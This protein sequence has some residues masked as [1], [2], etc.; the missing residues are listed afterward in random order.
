M[1]NLTLWD[2]NFVPWRSLMDMQRNMDR[3]FDQFISPSQGNAWSEAASSF[4]LPCDIDE[5]DDHYLMRFDV[6]GVSKKDINIDVR[7]NELHISGERKHER[8]S[9]GASERA[10]GKFERVL[11]LPTQI[12][13]DKI[14]ANYQDGVLSIA[15]PKQESAKARRIKIGEGKD[16]FLARLLGSKDESKKSE[17]AKEI[18]DSKAA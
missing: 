16:S 5:R 2:D 17:D 8:T 18:K 1:N 4:R 14:E 12:D 9:K 10:Y 11:S 13:P 15:V 7:G 6:P 3:L